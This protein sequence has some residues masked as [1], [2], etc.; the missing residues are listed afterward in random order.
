MIVAGDKTD[1]R[2][3]ISKLDYQNVIKVGFLNDDEPS[4]DKLQ[5]FEDQ[6]DVVI[7]GDGNF[8]SLTK[9]IQY[10]TSGLV[11]EGDDQVSQII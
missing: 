2:E 4:E 10:V 3:M 8:T 9:I 5:T 1:D 7:I 11:T 6:F